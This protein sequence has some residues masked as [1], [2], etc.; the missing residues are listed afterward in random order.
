MT[1]GEDTA[2]RHQRINQ[3]TRA[4]LTARVLEHAHQRRQLRRASAVRNVKPTPSRAVDTTCR[5]RLCLC[6]GRLLGL[7]LLLLLV[8]VGYGAGFARRVRVLVVV[9]VILAGWQWGWDC[10]RV[11][12]M[13]SCWKMSVVE[14]ISTYGLECLRTVEECDEC[15]LV[16]T[17]RWR[18]GGIQG[19]C[20]WMY[21]NL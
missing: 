7:L 13:W 12:C 16:H 21:G 18:G 10:R 6:L 17:K 2:A 1:T 5:R 11:G 9:R 8:H 20:R 3:G 4:S 14:F 19:G 15:V